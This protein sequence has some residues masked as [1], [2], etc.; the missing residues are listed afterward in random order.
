MG[1]L[2]A[3]TRRVRESMEKPV[4]ALSKHPSRGCVSQTPPGLVS[5]TRLTPAKRYFFKCATHS[6][7]GQFSIQVSGERAKGRENHGGRLQAT[8]RRHGFVRCNNEGQR[9]PCTT[10]GSEYLPRGGKERTGLVS[11]LLSRLASRLHPWLTLGR[12]MRLP[13]ASMIQG[14]DKQQHRREKTQEKLEF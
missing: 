5:V 12:G 1:Y 11:L 4:T 6:H 9:Q 8:W 2:T 7:I 10:R 3:P 13:R 14:A